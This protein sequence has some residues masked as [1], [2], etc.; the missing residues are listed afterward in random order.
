MS[1]PD[2]RETDLHPPINNST[3]KANNPSM[4]KKKIRRLIPKISLSLFTFVFLLLCGEIILRLMNIEDVSQP[5]YKKLVKYYAECLRLKPTTIRKKDSVRI[6]DPFLDYR[7]EPNATVK[8]RTPKIQLDVELDEL[9]FRANHDGFSGNEENLWFLGDSLTFGFVQELNDVFPK[10]VENTLNE[11]SGEI[12]FRALIHG[13]VGWSTVNVNRWVYRHGPSVKFRKA[14]L[15]FCVSNDVIGNLWYKN[16]PA[17]EPAVPRE[18]AMLR[19]LGKDDLPFLYKQSHLARLLWNKSPERYFKRYKIMVRPESLARTRTEL[20]RL[21]GVVGEGKL[22]VVIIPLL[23]QV[24]DSWVSNWFELD[25]IN[26]MVVSWC[27]ARHVPYIDLLE[28]IKGHREYFHPRDNHF[29]PEGN[30]AVGKIIA[31]FLME[32][33]GILEKAP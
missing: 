1:L 28:H 8:V 21:L 16:K 11:R 15:G 20:D 2:D 24:T 10:V 33:T 25:K 5:S 12:R 6:S 18:R 3:A 31:D 23:F 4:L 29:N 17:S 26:Q 22:V 14:I 30:H 7:F 27:E 32:Q 13:V 9:G 19:L